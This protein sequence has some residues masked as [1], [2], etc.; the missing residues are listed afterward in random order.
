MKLCVGPEL[1]FSQF[2]ITVVVMLV[3]ESLGWISFPQVFPASQRTPHTWEWITGAAAASLMLWSLALLSILH[4]LHRAVET[5]Q[6]WLRGNLAL[7]L[8][9]GAGDELGQLARQMDLLVQQLAQ[10]EQDLA[11]LRQR[12]ACLSD[13]VRALS[14][15]EE[16]N[17]LAR[18]LHGG[19]KQH[20]FSL[21]M[22]TSAIQERGLAAALHDYTLLFR[23]RK[24][25]LIYLDVQ[26]NDALLPLSIAETLYLVAQEALHNVVHHVRATRVDVKLQCLPEETSLFVHDNGC[27][28]DVD[29]PHHGLGVSNMHE[30]LLS[31]GGR[32]S[33]DSFP[34]RGTTI[35]AR[36]GLS[37][38]LP[39]ERA[40]T[41]LDR[42]RPRPVIENWV[43]LGQRIVI[44]VGQTWPWSPADEVYLRQ[45]LLETEQPIRLDVQAGFWG[46]GK[47]LHWQSDGLS[48]WIWSTFWGYA[49]RFKGGNWVF[50]GLKSL[51][52]SQVLFRNAQAPAAVQ[53]QGRQMDIWNE[54]IYAGRGYRLYPQDSANEYVLTDE[55]GEPLVELV[56]NGKKDIQV[57]VARSLPLLLVLMTVLCF[58]S[59][60]K[61]I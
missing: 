1:I 7:R 9:D 54:F 31:V 47:G 38:P 29:Q 56:A 27:G 36:V 34:G 35:I 26:G 42:N 60:K 13:Q 39:A 16:R 37:H 48:L 58:V 30:R 57:V 49:W 43:W 8:A 4:R 45:P 59:K 6:E 23:A 51:K 3:L 14:M 41:R 15:E 40:Y 53:Y 21:V 17:R 33:I 46:L 52:G 61:I 12:E 24:H 5:S 22:T 10:D 25:L 32:L 44:P 11:E 20:L 18:E 28:F 50:R 19:V 2:I 55:S